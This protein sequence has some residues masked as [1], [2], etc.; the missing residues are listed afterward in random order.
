MDAWLELRALIDVVLAMG[1]GGAVGFER[2]TKDR[3]AGFRLPGPDPL[4]KLFA[5]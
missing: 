4:K 1:L 3:P 2:E 5:A